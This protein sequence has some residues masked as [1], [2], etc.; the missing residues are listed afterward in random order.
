ME[1]INQ[2]TR[3]VKFFLCCFVCAWGRLVQIKGA[4]IAAASTRWGRTQAARQALMGR[5]AHSAEAKAAVRTGVTTRPR[6]RLGCAVELVLR[7]APL[8]RGVP[9]R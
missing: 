8:R 4:R 7:I 2:E 9:P 1:E 3:L 6:P 5:A